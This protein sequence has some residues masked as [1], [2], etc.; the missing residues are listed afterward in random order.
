M[1]KKSTDENAFRS[2][3]E[4]KQILRASSVI[5]DETVSIV[6]KRAFAFP[7][8]TGS[9][10]ITRVFAGLDVVDLQLRKKTK[11]ILV[12]PYTTVPRS[13]LVEAIRALNKLTPRSSMNIDDST[14]K[15]AQR[16]AHIAFSLLRRLIS[17]IG[18]R[19]PLRNGISISKQ[20]MI[21]ERDFCS[22]LRAFVE[23]DN[24][25]MAHKIMA[26]QE[27]TVDA[28]DLSSVPYSI[29]IKA[30]GRLG[31]A[32]N[33]QRVWR[34]TTLAIEPDVIM[35]NSAID[36]FVNCGKLNLAED[37]FSAM[38]KPDLNSM[39]RPSN[40]LPS[41][42]TRTFNTMLKGY[43]KAAS[44]EKASKLYKTIEE[45]GLN[46]DHI[47]TNTLVSAAVSSGSFDT[48]ESILANHTYTIDAQV[49]GVQKHYHSRK[50]HPNVEAYTELLDGYAKA[51][52]LNKALNTLKLMRE[53]DV[54]PNVYTYS[55]LIGALAR[56]DKILQAKKMLEFMEYTDHISPNVITYNAFLTGMLTRPEIKKISHNSAAMMDLTVSMETRE[57]EAFH[58]LSKMTNSGIRPNA[59]TVASLVEF[60]SIHCSPS[61]INVARDLVATLDKAYKGHKYMHDKRV[62]TIFIKAYSISADLDSATIVFSDIH[63]PDV[64]AL[65]AYLDACCQCDKIKLAMENFNQICA[66]ETRRIAPDVVTY[67][68]II[69]SLLEYKD[70]LRAASKVRELYLEMKNVE[71]ILPDTGLVDLILTAMITGGRIGV[72]KADIKFTLDILR[73]AE[74]LEWPSGYLERRQKIVRGVILG[75][76]SEVWKLKEDHYGM[77]SKLE[78][79]LFKKKGWNTVDS[80]FRLWGGGNNEV[81]ETYK[82]SRR[83]KTDEFL[84]S[85]GWNDMDS[86]FRLL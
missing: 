49:D 59:V 71:G 63:N 18:V 74:S 29:L 61:R 53:R 16:R 8:Y 21:A 9:E 33:V 34:R 66:L 73:D 28:P 12:A 84:E 65:N 75:R 41:P 30:Y 47:T 6:T 68:V 3:Q 67:S 62:A 20:F 83:S 52:M 64:V 27:R 15:W 13:T 77:N 58:L 60:L 80:G 55:S 39:E 56:S 22:V 17:G 5:I 32:S 54:Q 37:I 50:K 31:D 23:V 40:K 38:M 26:L 51:G 10:V 48:A 4:K 86:G 14:S 82:P 79:P 11:G 42:N 35:C 43:A 81:S 1:V 78:D 70:N 45:K 46:W 76:V 85:K 44:W 25:D 36:A 2:Q 57:E 69:S 19:Q 7:I 24:M 72:D